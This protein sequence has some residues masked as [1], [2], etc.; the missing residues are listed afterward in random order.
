M[1]KGS[2]KP[3]MLGRPL[4]HINVRNPASKKRELNIKTVSAWRKFQDRSCYDPHQGPRE[5]ERRRRKH[6]SQS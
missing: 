5:M 4:V 1:A 3:K 2:S 6:G